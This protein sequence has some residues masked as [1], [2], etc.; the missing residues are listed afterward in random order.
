MSVQT[1][2]H[3]TATIQRLND[4][5]RQ[6]FAGGKVMIS[7]GVAE[8]ETQLKVAVMTGVQQFSDFS[9]NNDP[10]SEHDFGALELGPRKFFWKIYYDPSMDAGSE[11]PSD[12]KEATRVLTIMLAD[13]Y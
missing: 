6:T 2:D 1:L 12:P 9:E 11:D 8:L 13:E 4:T 5:F 10:H 3:K 7:A